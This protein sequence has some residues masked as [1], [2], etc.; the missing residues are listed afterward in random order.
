MVTMFVDASSLM[1]G[2]AH[3]IGSIVLTPIP[4]QKTHGGMNGSG[5]VN[6]W[7]GHA[8]T[9]KIEFKRAFTVQ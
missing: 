8:E 1:L 9:T 5:L 7:D 2:S 6:I 3:C 4:M